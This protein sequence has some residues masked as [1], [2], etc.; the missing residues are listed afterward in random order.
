MPAAPWIP[1][2]PIFWGPFCPERYKTFLLLPQGKQIKEMPQPH[3]LIPWYFKYSLFGSPRAV[4]VLC[5]SLPG[6]K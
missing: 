6:Q 5:F 1:D 4:L 2:H 3:F